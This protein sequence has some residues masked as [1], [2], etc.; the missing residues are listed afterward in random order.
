MMMMLILMTKLIHTLD[1]TVGADNVKSFDD[2][3]V[4]GG[5]D[6]DC[7]DETVY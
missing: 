2:G 6:E 4:N 1:E 3:F 5:T 7:D